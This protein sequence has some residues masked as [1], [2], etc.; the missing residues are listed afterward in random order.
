MIFNLINNLKG[1]VHVMKNT[2]NVVRN[3]RVD[4]LKAQVSITATGKKNTVLA[5]TGKYGQGYDGCGT[6]THK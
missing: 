5:Y 1:S 3:D 2:S 4:G 6:H